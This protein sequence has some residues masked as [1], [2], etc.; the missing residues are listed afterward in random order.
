MFKA[1]LL[2][3]IIAAGFIVGPLWSG[4]TGY[5]L[6]AV[7]GYTIETSVVLLVVALLLL[8][9]VLWFFEWLVRKI[10]ASKRR[11]SGWLR[12]RRQRKAK[13]AFEQALQSWLSRD[14]EK[15]QVEAEQSA[16]ALS[17][18]YPAY[19]LAAMAANQSGDADAHQRLLQKAAASDEH[20]SLPVRLAAVESAAPETARRELE[21]LRQ[22]HAD[23]R[24]VLR[25]AVRVYE[26]HQFWSEL[27]DILP[28]LEKHALVPA[29][30]LNSLQHQAFRDYFTQ[31]EQTSAAL[32]QAWKQL[33]RKQRHRAAIRL[34]YIRALLQVGDTEQ[35]QRQ[36]IYGLRK[37]YLEPQHLLYGQN[38]FNWQGATE[39]VEHLEE[40]VKAAPKD[41]QALALLGLLAMQQTDF[42]LAQRA[43]RK[44]LELAPS[45]R[46][47][48]LLGDAH[49]AAGQSAQALDAYQAASAQE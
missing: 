43:L 9:G 1:L 28:L 12:N 30:H 13:R 4:Q 19:L 39:L 2:L 16:R 29:P 27:R 34:E 42:D 36:A 7:A 23:H 37:E 41:S 48:R 11:G 26:R 8:V 10:I 15:A 21:R 47:Y 46:F 35:A 18:P 49:L 44:A 40:R 24:G 32:Q 3:L 17:E 38:Q 31:T 20:S 45:K 6:I 33:A 5:V 14:Y 22:Q 25:V